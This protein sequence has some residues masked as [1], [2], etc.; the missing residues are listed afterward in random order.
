MKIIYTVFLFIISNTFVSNVLAQVAPNFQITDTEG[1]SHDLYEDYLDKD[2]TV[3]LKFFFVNCPPC[4]GIAP[5]VQELYEEWGEGDE[6]VEFMELSILA[7]DSNEDV[8]TFKTR[9]GITFPGAG[10]DGDALGAVAPYTDGDFGSFKGTPSFAVIAPDRS[11]VYNTGG[12]GNSGKINNLSEA[13]AATGA[14]GGAPQPAVYSLRVEDGFGQKIEG[15][16]YSIASAS[17]PSLTFD[18]SV[19]TSGFSISDLASEFPGI[20]DPV[21]ILE[22]TDDIRKNITPLDILLIRKHILG[23]ITQT[24]PSVI[25][26]ADT[27]GDGQVTPLDMLVLQKVILGIFTE[28]PVDSHLFIPNE[29]PLDILPGNTTELD[30]K[31]TKVG[32]LNGF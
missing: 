3:V 16:K 8:Q 14:T 21:L 32:D 17:D 29:I 23:V 27:N 10:S 18:V 9:H 7:G 6:D 5:Q 25:A 4:N 15:I 1:V 11:V 30:I 31:V 12:L 24:E 13:I 28:F 26:A 20:E 19:D 2:I 22:K